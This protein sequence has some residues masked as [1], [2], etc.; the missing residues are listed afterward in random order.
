M[1]ES[2]KR[3]DHPNLVVVHYN[4]YAGGK[5]FIN[6]L[7]HHEQVLPGLLEIVAAG[8]VFPLA[9]GEPGHRFCPGNPAHS[10]RFSPAT[11]R[12]HLIGLGL[13]N[14]QLD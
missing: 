13:K 1:H 11:N 4:Q 9:A 10:D 3:M 7:A 6:C 2:I 14:E 5:F 12:L 8:R